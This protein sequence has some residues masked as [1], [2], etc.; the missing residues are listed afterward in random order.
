MS[1][2]AVAVLV[3]AQMATIAIAGTG[4]TAEL[5]LPPRSGKPSAAAFEPGRPIIGRK[6]AP[7]ILIEFGEFQCPFT[8]RARAAVRAALA[9]HGS[10]MIYSYR[11]LPL[12]QHGEPARLASEYFEAVLAVSPK[13]SWEFFD[14]LFD[15][16]KAIGDAGEPAIRELVA[17]MGVSLAAVDSERKHSTIHKHIRNDIIAARQL[18]LNETPTFF[19]NG[20]RYVGEPAEREL[21]SRIDAVLNSSKAAK[22][23]MKPPVG[24]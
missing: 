6:G 12:S 10:R 21:V 2:G 8:D 23:G 22:A 18:G 17:S 14:A 5:N 19:I 7:I 15:N 9:K 3:A 20:V 24:R 13:K 1:R 11:H 4:H 16:R